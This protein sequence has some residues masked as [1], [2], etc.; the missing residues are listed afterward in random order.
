MTNQTT[1]LVLWQERLDETPLLLAQLKHMHV[2]Q[3]L[4]EC[5]VTHGNWQGLSLGNLT[6]VWLAFILAEGN[7]R[8]SHL[9]EWVA[10][11]TLSLQAALGVTFV[12]T[13]FTD[14]RLAQVLDYLHREAAWTAFEEKLNAWLLRVY[15]LATDTIR[16]DS[17]SAKSFGMVTPEGLLQFGHSKDH[18][19]DLPQFKIQ[20]ST[21][22]P[23][24]LPLTA[25]ITSGEKAD[26]PLYV[27]EIDRVRQTLGK[28]GLLYVGDCKMAALDTRLHL[29]AGGDFYLCPLSAVQV[30]ATA[31]AV[32]LA[33]VRTGVQ[34]VQPVWR[35]NDE[36]GRREKIAEGFEYE[37]TLTG[38]QDGQPVVWTERRLVVRGLA[39]AKAQ[40]AGLRKRLTQARAAIR[41]LGQRKKGKTCPRTEAEWQA[42]VDKI[43]TR[44]RV[45]GLLQV[46]YEVTRQTRTVRAYGA[47]TAREIEQESVRVKVTTD[48]AAVATAESQLGW[49][50]Y[51]TNAPATQL[52]LTQA[53]LAYR[54]SFLI[55]RGFR[56]LKGR[57]LS[58]TP[59]YL[60][61][62]ARLT[63]LV[64]VLLIGL[65]VLGLI[66]Y[67]ARRA[68][69]AAQETLAGLTKGLP[70][71]ATARP[72][73]EAMLQALT[74]I[75][76]FG[77]GTQWYLTPLTALQQRILKLLGFSEDIYHQ[78]LQA[79]SN[80]PLKIGET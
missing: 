29:A 46:T 15:D 25:T 41:Q 77:V 3:L 54:G 45:V 2:P 55:E 65:R 33:P 12:E 27:P 43:L 53:V 40:K 19:P 31:L 4:D 26:D 63:G 60:T 59:L 79:I 14:D 61:T 52:S 9:R 44:Q 24:G 22:D 32:L 36:T 37:I 67:Q 21:L 18:R 78:I 13:D 69:A 38:E 64:R 28:R 11:R 80:T 42:A 58:L 74:G 10:A 1:D 39:Q 57:Q 56:R 75:T 48:A 76:L 8:L 23:L 34:A 50:V 30:P 62:P 47:R 17:T 66:E 72:T 68:L 73:A 49:R 16:L 6:V 20:L 71:K 35:K 7:H 51:A 5:F 70:K